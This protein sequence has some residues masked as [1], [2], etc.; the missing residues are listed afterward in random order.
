[1][2]STQHKVL[3]L[4]V[5]LHIQKL[6]P[7]WGLLLWGFFLTL[8]SAKWQLSAAHL[9]P[10]PFPP[11]PPISL[12]RSRLNVWKIQGR[13]AGKQLN[14]LTYSF[15]L[16]IQ[17]TKVM[18]NHYLEVKEEGRGVEEIFLKGKGQQQYLSSVEVIPP[19]VFLNA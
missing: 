15:S 16:E 11:P 8:S 3:F 7:S 13:T 1:M 14:R 2:P 19:Y 6:R 5:E 9:H 4:P 18:I 10:A 17:L 12:A